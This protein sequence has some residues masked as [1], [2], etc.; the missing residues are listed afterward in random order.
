MT[1]PSPGTRAA[2][3]PVRVFQ[4]FLA[5]WVYKSPLDGFAHRGH[6]I[7]P[8]DARRQNGGFHS[9]GVAVFPSPGEFPVISGAF[10]PWRQ[11]LPPDAGGAHRGMTAG[12]WRLLYTR[13]KMAG[14]GVFAHCPRGSG[15]RYPPADRGVYSAINLFCVLYPGYGWPPL[16]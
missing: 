6:S 5:P 13:G 16:P 2:R 7:A 15:R 10:R 11:T 12:K 14:G 3:P 8:P 1:A 9:R 4:H